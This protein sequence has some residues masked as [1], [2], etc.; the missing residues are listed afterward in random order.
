MNTLNQIISWMQ[1][2]IGI[3]LILRMVIICIKI[4]TNEEEKSQNIRRLKHCIIAAIIVT[5]IIGLK[6]LIGSYFGRYG[7]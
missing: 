2:A 3:G 5:V 7:I 1:G 4:I 6:S